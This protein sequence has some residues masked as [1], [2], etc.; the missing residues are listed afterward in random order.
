MS[1]SQSVTEILEKLKQ[2]TLLETAELV[3]QIETTFDVSSSVSSPS[4]MIIADSKNQDEDIDN[5][6]KS[7]EEKTEFDIVIEKVP[8]DK[9]IAIIKIVRSVTTLGLKEAKALIE[10]VPS[11]VKEAISKDEAEDIKKKLENAGAV[12]LLK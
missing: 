7:K 12:V 2:L 8:T 3:K 10:T 6:T 4:P 5:Q 9:R 1:T 11:P